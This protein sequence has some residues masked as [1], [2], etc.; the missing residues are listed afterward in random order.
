MPRVIKKESGKKISPEKEIQETIVDMK[1]RLKR[2]QKLLIFSLIA[3]LII[4]GSGAGFIIY[5]KSA[6]NKASLLEYEGLK[7]YYGQFQATANLSDDRYKKALEKFTESYNTKKNPNVLFY[8]A[9]CHYESGNYDE[10][11]KTLKELV[12]RFSEPQFVS[13]S[14]YKMA[15]AYL[16]KND[17]ENALNNLQSLVKL[18]GGIL[19][20]LAL[21]EIAKILETTGKAEGAKDAYKEL[22][23]KYPKSAFANEA[24]LRIEEK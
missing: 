19:Q 17:T 7:L 5:N 18:K 22:I 4:I 15:M 9:N 16:K 3:F 14:Y 1:D 2:R 10:A 20:D 13:Y 23:E 21:M 24:K 12:S 8:I 11:I 6:S